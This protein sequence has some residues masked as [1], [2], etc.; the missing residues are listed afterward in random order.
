MPATNVAS[1]AVAG[2]ARA[3]EFRERTDGNEN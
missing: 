2:T 3:Y 1:T